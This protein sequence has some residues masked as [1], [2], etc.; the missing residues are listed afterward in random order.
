MA[1]SNPVLGFEITY[2]S[3][4][5]GSFP[6]INQCTI[7]S[8]FFLT[9]FSKFLKLETTPILSATPKV[10]QTLKHISWT[11]KISTCYLLWRSFRVH[12]S[13]QDMVQRVV[14]LLLALLAV[15][16]SDIIGFL[17]KNDQKSFLKQQENIPI[18]DIHRN[19][20]QR[21]RR[22]AGDPTY[23]KNDLQDSNNYGLVHYSGGNSNVSSQRQQKECW[24]YFKKKNKLMSASSNIVCMVP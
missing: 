9:R 5:Q 17:P 1:K 16:Q 12:S 13:R 2:H 15:A 10:M 3:R 14:C 18:E 4:S 6:S 21:T 8:H 7:L 20:L 19:L 24:A 22:A 23:T 11:A